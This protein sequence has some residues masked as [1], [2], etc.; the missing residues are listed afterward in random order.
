MATAVGRRPGT[1]RA[2]K[3]AAKIVA[4]LKNRVGA[5]AI[6]N[7]AEQDML[8]QFEE[9]AQGEMDEPAPESEAQ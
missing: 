5:G 2:A 1:T 8:E 7:I 4:N 6:S 3:I 9:I